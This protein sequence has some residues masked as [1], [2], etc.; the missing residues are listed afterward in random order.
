MIT[1]IH[2]EAYIIEIELES[3]L[4]RLLWGIIL[5]DETGRWRPGDY[6]CT[7]PIQETEEPGN[8]VTRFKTR[9]GSIY[10]ARCPV[11]IYKPTSA[12]ECMHLRA[13][14][15]PGDADWFN[16]NGFQVVG[17]EQDN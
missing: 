8:G 14:L 5:F 6:V 16:R 9:S 10:E 7:S 11:V 3:Q 12:S 13:G 1:A 15:S 2:E 4:F 17:L